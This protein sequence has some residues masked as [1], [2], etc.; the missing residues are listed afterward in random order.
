[1]KR[2]NESLVKRD[3]APLPP[4]ITPRSLS[5]TFCSVLY[6]F[7]EWPPVVMA[8]MKHTDPVLALS[9]YAQAMRRSPEEQAALAALVD[10][11]GTVPGAELWSIVVDEAAEDVLVEDGEGVK[12]AYLQAK[13]P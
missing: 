9:V 2:A 10:G 6:A 5:R 3:L 7:N 1:V 12:T 4:R 13:R 11:T 8:E